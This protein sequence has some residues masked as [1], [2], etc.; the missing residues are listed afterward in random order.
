MSTASAPDRRSAG[1]SG[2]VSTSPGLAPRLAAA[3]LAAALV[4]VA[5]VTTLPAPASAA[6]P[7]LQ[8][9]S[10]SSDT[11]SR[12]HKGARAE[13]PDD[14]VAIGSGAT[15]EGGLGEV[16]IES[17]V[18]SGDGVSALA[19]EDAN[20]TSNLWKV[21]AQAICASPPPGHTIV[22]AASS[23]TAVNKSVTASCPGDTV[24]IGSGAL[25]SG[26]FGD[27]ELEEIR[28]E[29]ASVTVT[30]NEIGAGIAT[31]WAVY[32]YASCA[33]PLPGQ[34]TVSAIGANTAAAK[35]VVATCPAGTEVINAAG[36]LDN[37]DGRVLLDD[38]FADA[39][40]V[41]ATGKETGNGTGTP[42]RVEAIALCATP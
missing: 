5:T 9:I 24:V 3:A 8:I 13:C 15:I 42:W 6:V 16:N 26:S 22:Y 29:L 19:Y 37:G 28:P 1:S 30:G 11:D 33:D 41:T 18:P 12:D 25:L 36:R 39:T 17:V 40:T 23:Q 34:V 35:S 21:T 32:A 20:G 4:A 38:L 10:V 31:P 2:R 27:V 7:E 14:T